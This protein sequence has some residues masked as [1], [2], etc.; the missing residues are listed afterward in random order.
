MWDK[1]GEFNSAAELNE[2]AAGQKEQ[3]DREA[4]IELAVENGIDREDAE[5]Y[6]NGDVDFL[7]T[8]VTA[9]LGKL[10]VEA[11]DVKLIGIELD[12]Y[13]YIKQLAMEEPKIG[14]NIRK[15]DRTLIGCIGKLFKWGADNMQP[16]D[17][18]IVKAASIKGLS[19][20]KEGTPDMA[21]AKDIIRRY[22]A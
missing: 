11:A 20:A 3:G 9:A 7:C 6:M 15:K 5:D 12:W 1:F 2:A 22:Y 18:R 14:E 10:K 8:V 19:S 4:L 16:V 17:D 21:T 13:E